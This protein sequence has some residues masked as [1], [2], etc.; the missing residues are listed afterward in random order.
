MH[1]PNGGI[2]IIILVGIIADW[3]AGQV[4]RGTGFGLVGI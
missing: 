2:L 4:M 3:V 1:L